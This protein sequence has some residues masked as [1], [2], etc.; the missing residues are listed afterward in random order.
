MRAPNNSVHGGCNITLKLCSVLSNVKS[1][2]KTSP[3]RSSASTSRPQCLKPPFCLC[4]LN[5]HGDL[6][7]KLCILVTNPRWSSG[8]CACTS[9]PGCCNVA[10]QDTTV[11]LKHQIRNTNKPRMPIVLILS[12][13]VLL[14]CCLMASTC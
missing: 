1:F 12:V 11:C 13:H 4:L 2:C 5:F 3:M 7:A 10:V 8:P 6:T 9:F 14:T